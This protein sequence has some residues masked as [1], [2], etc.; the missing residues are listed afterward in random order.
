MEN[1][2]AAASVSIQM[3][4]KEKKRGATQLLRPS[5]SAR[6]A[7]TLRTTNHPLKIT[8]KPTFVVYVVAT[9]KVH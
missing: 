4:R 7:D 6:I 5:R 2:E 3:H 8:S 1:W 9:R